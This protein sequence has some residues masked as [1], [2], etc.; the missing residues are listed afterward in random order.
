M[1]TTD[2]PQ[3][4]ALVEPRWGIPDAV[5]GWV[6]AMQAGTIIGGALIAAFGN[7]GE[8]AKADN[9]SS[10]GTRCEPEDSSDAA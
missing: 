3:Q 7:T 4:R 9:R 10:T 8:A 6:V 5:V 2:V 1:A